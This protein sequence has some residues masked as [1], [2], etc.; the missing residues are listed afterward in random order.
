[1]QHRLLPST[2]LQE[3][4]SLARLN[5]RLDVDS[6][7]H[8]SHRFY[9]NKGNTGMDVD[10][11]SDRIARSHPKLHFLS[12]SSCSNLHCAHVFRGVSLESS[13]FVQTLSRK[14]PLCLVSRYASHPVEARTRSRCR[15][16]VARSNFPT[17]NNACQIRMEQLTRDAKNKVVALGRLVRWT[18]VREGLKRSVLLHLCLSWITTPRDQSKR[19]DDDLLLSGGIDQDEYRPRTRRNEVVQANVHPCPSTLSSAKEECVSLCVR[20][21]QPF[22]QASSIDSLKLPRTLQSAACFRVYASQL[23]SIPT[24]TINKQHS[25]L[26]DK[27]TGKTSCASSLNPCARR[28]AKY[29]FLI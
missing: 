2:A 3:I 8:L 15:A 6:E 24:R 19:E 21:P 13:P 7:L 26:V 17:P 18:D 29:N 23:L 4:Q 28:S 14:N 12:G 27:S 9:H 22:T 1:M 25:R 10:A 16:D 5:I 20:S 11:S